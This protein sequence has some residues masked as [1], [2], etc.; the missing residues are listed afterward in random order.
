MDEIKRFENLRFLF[1]KKL[2]LKK[3][4]WFFAAIFFSNLFYVRISKPDNLF[5]AF[6][7]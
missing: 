2:Q 4:I 3:P 1:I 6:F 7:I 5:T